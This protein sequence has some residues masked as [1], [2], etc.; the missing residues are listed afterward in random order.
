MATDP[1]ATAKIIAG[2][3]SRMRDDHRRVDHF[4]MAVT[5]ILTEGNSESAK[6]IPSN[7]REPK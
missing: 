4:Q 3:V 5:E 1:V 7:R 2:H 6:N